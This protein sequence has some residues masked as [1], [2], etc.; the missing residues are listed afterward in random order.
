MRAKWI[1]GCVLAVA[2]G[3]WAA[4][5]PTAAVADKAETQRAD[6]A[7]ELDK[8]YIDPLHG[9]SIRPPAGTERKREFSTSTIVTWSKRDEK[10]GAV[11]WTL[12]VQKAGESNKSIDLKPYSEVLAKKLSA[13]DDYKIES[14]ELGLLADKGTIHFRGLTGG[15]AKLWQRQAWVLARP[16]EF[17]IFAITG[18]RDSKEQ[19]D[20]LFQAV[21]GTLELSDPQKATE[22]RKQN[23]ARGKDLLGALKD[24]QLGR[25]L[26]AETQWFLLQLKGEDIG[27]MAQVEM[28]NRRD[29][30]DGCEVRSWVMMQLPKDKPRILRRLLFTTADRSFEKW[31]EKLDV[32]SGKEMTNISEEGIK[33]AEMIVCNITAEGKTQPQRKKLPQDL[34]PQKFSLGDYYL[35]RAMGV[36]LPRLVDL[37]KPAAYSFAIYN[38]QVNNFDMRTFTIVGAEKITLNQARV[39]AVK[40]TDQAA[41]DVEPAE[42][43]LSAKGLLL[44]MTTSDGLVMEATSRAAILERFPKAEE[45]AKEVGK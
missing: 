11:A 18:P 8:R 7:A 1:A 45:I 4:D 3:A 13:N 32:G 36:L 23:I 43:W 39:D 42:L 10:T 38:T 6:S 20:K 19:L 26:G 35:P 2:A 5:K 28:A 16:G 25:A 31:V 14:V 12:T 33:Q 15:A 44:R 29:G 30:A 34:V 21:V 41:P 27:F 9:F 17:L 37:S 24:Q 40:A 22:E